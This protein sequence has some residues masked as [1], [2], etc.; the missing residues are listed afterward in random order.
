MF[1]AVRIA[2]LLRHVLKPHPTVKTTV[3]WGMSLCTLLYHTTVQNTTTSPEKMNILVFFHKQ[4]KSAAEKE[5]NLHQP[6]FLRRLLIFQ[7]I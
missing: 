7:G 4:D 2:L 3:F 1:F 6:S 5:Y